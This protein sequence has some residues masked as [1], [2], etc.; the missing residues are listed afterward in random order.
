MEDEN[1]EETPPESPPQEAAPASAPSQE[2]PHWRKSKEGT[3][4]IC[5][6]VDT[7]QPNAKIDVF[8]K[9]GSSSGQ[10]LGADPEAFGEPF[11]SRNEPG[12]MLRYAYKFEEVKE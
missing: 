7:M 11:E 10:I 1:M 8:R 3:W 6:P 12:V 4:V 2:R 5:G 9:D